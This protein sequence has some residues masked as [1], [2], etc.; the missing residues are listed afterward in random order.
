VDTIAFG[1]VAPMLKGIPAFHESVPSPRLLAKR[2]PFPDQD[3]N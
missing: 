3:D 1:E 2:L